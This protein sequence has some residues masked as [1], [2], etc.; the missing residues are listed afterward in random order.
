MLGRRSRPASTAS[1]ASG[2]GSCSRQCRMQPELTVRESLELYAGYY[3]E[4]A[5]GR[6]HDRARRP[7]A[8]RPT[9]ASA[10]LSGGQQRRLDVALALIGDPE[11]LFLDE[12][13][14]GFDPSA[15]RQA[16]E[17]VGEPARPRQDRV[18]D[19][20][21][22]GR[23]A[24]AR[25]PRGD[26]RRAAQ[27]VAEGSP[28]RA[29]RPRRRRPA[30]I[31]F[32]LPA[33]VSPAPSCPGRSRGGGRQRRGR[34]A[35]GRPGPRPQR[36]HRLGA[37]APRR[38]SRGCEV[39]RP[40]LEDVYLE[41]T[42]DERRG[43]RGMSGVALALHQFRF[44][45]KTFWRNPASVFFTVMLPVIFLL[46]FDADLRQ[47]PRSRSSA[48]VK[49]THLLRAGDHHPRRRLGDLAE[50][51]DLAHR[52][53][54]ERAPQAGPRARRCRAWVFIAGRI[55]NSIVVSV[56]MLVV[57]W[58]RS[59]GS[60]TGSTIP[61]DRL[62]AVLVTLAIGAAAFC[63]PR[64]RADRRHPDGGRAPRRSPTSRSCRCT[65]SPA[66]SSPRAR[67]PTACSTS[68][69]CSRSATSSRRSS[70]PGTRD[71]RRRLRVGPPGGG[72]RLGARRPRCS[73]SAPSAGRRGR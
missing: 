61:W 60:S 62:P 32:R 24:G 41:L 15:R 53:P 48:G 63:L 3:R 11:L 44:D 34:P 57:V 36:A 45:Q 73:R 38:R 59:G 22:H 49:T 10:R 16:W 56:L 25:R 72:R 39:R 35:G 9:I 27:I 52:R 54:R 64:A 26:H 21:L 20:A 13:T 43:G 65:S 1:G 50:P 42:A 33:G 12:P 29:R 23:G 66:S 14:T 31:S 4:P 37:G 19:H 6:R 67:S 40:S 46:I 55:G 8:R 58:R 69:T 71:R 51:G 18:P 2:S 47:R 70:P 30:T 5:R 28:G 17:V 68:P 7:R